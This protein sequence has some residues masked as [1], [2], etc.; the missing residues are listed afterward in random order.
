MHCFC[1]QCP[2]RFAAPVIRVY[3]LPRV[4]NA[5]VAKAVIGVCLHMGCAKLRRTHTFW[6]AADSLVQRGGGGG[7]PVPKVRGAKG[8]KE[9]FP[10]GCIGVVEEK[11][12]KSP[13]TRVGVI[14]GP[15]LPGLGETVAPFGGTIHGGWDT[16]TNALSN[17]HFR[18]D[19]IVLGAS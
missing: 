18:S 2:F 11:S 16:P 3:K 14:W 10:S 13:P 19:Q 5:F 17:E 4:S 7:S 9:N 6:A 1:L 15:F 8:A 12:G